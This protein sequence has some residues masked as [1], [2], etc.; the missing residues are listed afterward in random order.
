MTSE[1]QTDEDYEMERMTDEEI[2]ELGK[3]LQ[4]EDYIRIPEEKAEGARECWNCGC[5]CTLGICYTL[6]IK[7]EH[8]R[9]HLRDFCS[10]E[11]L[12]EYVGGLV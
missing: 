12:R 8:G 5:S 1:V 9:E 3:R 7:P 11:C 4:Q 6:V 2:V 10:V